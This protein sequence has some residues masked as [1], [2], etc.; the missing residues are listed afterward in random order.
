MVSCE[1]RRRRASARC[2]PMKPA[3]PVSSIFFAASG[4]RFGSVSVSCDPVAYCSKYRR[5]LGIPQQRVTSS[6]VNFH[7]FVA[8]AE[9][10]EKFERSGLADD[11][12]LRALEKQRG[13]GD[14]W[15]D[16]SSPMSR[17]GADLF[18]VSDADFIVGQRIGFAI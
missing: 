15:S 16:E 1:P 7:G 8:G 3:P 17:G 14:V 9:L 18:H 5:S 11:R 6:I 13:H 10:L 4:I 2:E 12:I